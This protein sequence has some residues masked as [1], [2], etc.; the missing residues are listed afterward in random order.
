M[1]KLIIAGMA[2]AVLAVPAAASASQPVNPGGFGQERSANIH[3]YFTS[4][5]Y[6]SWGNPTDGTGID[7]ASD[8]KGENSLNTTYMRTYDQSLPV[9]SHAG[10]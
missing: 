5:G 2:V 6:G 3:A 4:D 8:R 7:G 10:L 1:R 9:E